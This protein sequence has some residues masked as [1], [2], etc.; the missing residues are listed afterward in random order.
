MKR[1]LNFTIFFCIITTFL[2][3][4]DSLSESE[5]YWHQWRGPQASGVALHGDPPIEWNE[6][7]NVRWKIEIPGQGHATP[8]VWDDTIFV[9][10]AIKTDKQVE[11]TGRTRTC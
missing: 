11:T 10:S 4:T 6:N 2:W 8:I 3:G 9:T 5:K 1:A 7:K